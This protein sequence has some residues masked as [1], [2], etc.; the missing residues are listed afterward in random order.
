MALSLA[1][2]PVIYPW[3]LLYFTPFLWTRRAIPLVVWTMSVLPVYVVWQ[4]SREGARWIVP[5][6]I[7]ALEFGLVL[8]AAVVLAVLARSRMRLGPPTTEELV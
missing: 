7:E 1:C 4:R 3:Y 6:P 8:G 2:S 5:W